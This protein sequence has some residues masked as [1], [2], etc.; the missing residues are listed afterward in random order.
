MV[1]G[2][3]SRSGSVGGTGSRGCSGSDTV[4]G[5]RTMNEAQCPVLRRCQSAG[6]DGGSPG[7]GAWFNPWCDRHLWLVREGSGFPGRLLE[8]LAPQLCAETE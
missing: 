6:E 1:L 7:S 5:S 8:V 2:W 3:S 4:S